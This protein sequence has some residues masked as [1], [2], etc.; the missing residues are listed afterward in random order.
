[1]MARQSVTGGWSE[2]QEEPGIAPEQHPWNWQ[3]RGRREFN[4]DWAAVREV[5]MCDVM[6]KV[7][8]LCADNPEWSCAWGADVWGADPLGQRKWED[9]LLLTHEQEISSG[10]VPMILV[11]SVEVKKREGVQVAAYPGL[12]NGSKGWQT[13]GCQWKPWSDYQRPGFFGQIWRESADTMPVARGRKY[14]HG[15]EPPACVDKIAELIRGAH[16]SRGSL[17]AAW[18]FLDYSSEEYQWVVASPVGQSI[19]AEARIHIHNAGD[20]SASGY[21]GWA[22]ATLWEGAKD[23]LPFPAEVPAGMARRQRVE[24]PLT[25]TGPAAEPEGRGQRKPRRAEAQAVGPTRAVALSLF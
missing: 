17:L 11:A 4:F 3:E 7:Q 1:M 12:F 8:T 19:I 9:A 13:F 18:C 22:L 2:V 16:P 21:Y 25:E 14:L 10:V 15:D 20:K 24:K 23:D 6:A 5:V